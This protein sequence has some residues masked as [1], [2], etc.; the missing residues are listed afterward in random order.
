MWSAIGRATGRQVR[1]G[2]RLLIRQL[3][4]RTASV[5][6]SGIRVAAV[7]T[8]GFAEAGRPTKATKTATSTATKTKKPTA[9][10]AATKKAA[11][12]KTGAKKA[13]KAKAPAKRKPRVFKPKKPLTEE[14]KT[15]L[16][17][18][19][20]KKRALLKEEPTRLPI[21]SWVV[22]A[23]QRVKSLMG[24]DPAIRFSDAMQLLSAEYK[25]LTPEEIEQLD[26]VGRQNKVANDVTYRNWVD[27]YTAQ[28]IHDANLA[29]H[30][31]RRKHSAKIKPTIDDPRFPNKH[32]SSYVAYMKSRFHAPDLEAHTGQVRF[33]KI[34]AEWK[35][36]GAEE[37]KPFDEIAA[38]DLARFK[39][40]MEGYRRE[41]G[42]L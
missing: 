25:A 31:L 6:P 14:D 8:R 21:T 26:A 22:F 36:L 15:K 7:F 33:T 4:P 9:K 39:K 1:V 3:A 23:A 35:Q 42:K 16:A 13:T 27:S 37:R 28:E 20:L 24:G 38:V 19:V 17:I 11:T 30:L 41:A 12:K 2:G 5:I 32:M 34:A 29:R 10:K 18:K 40:E